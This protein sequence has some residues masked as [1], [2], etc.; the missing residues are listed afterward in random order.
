MAAANKRID[1]KWVVLLLVSVAYFLAQGTRHIYAAVLPQIKADLA[2]G[3]IDDTRLGLVSSV[4]NLVFGL[5]MPF[6]GLAADL[7]R[8]K[9]VLVTGSLLFAVGIFCSGFA[10]GL[11][12]LFI[13]YGILNAVGQSLM[14][15]CNTSFISQYHDRTRGTAFSLYQSAI[16]LGIIVCSIVSGYLAGMGE[17]GW[18]K[19]F[20]LFGAISFVWAVVM[21]LTLKDSQPG[22]S[23]DDKEG[24]GS[25]AEAFKAFARK[26]T[27]FVLMAALGFY[28]F[29]TYAFKT[30]SPMFMMRAFPEMEPARAIF[31]AVFWFYVGAL[32]GVTLGGRVSDRWRQL[33]RTARLDTELIGFALCVPFILVMASARSLPLMI[34]AIALFG[35]ATGIYDSNL[36][37]ALFEVIN[38]RY[39]A[40]AT[41][42]F[43]C[44]GCV[45]GALGPVVA[46]A[47]SDSFD[48]RIAF[49]SLALFALFGTASIVLARLVTFK[50]DILEQ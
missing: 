38:P 22:P 48:I 44:G 25:I 12:M 43:G 16:Y 35:F 31:H 17:G 15:P 7:L 3:G 24:L 23:A 46:G 5:M 30:W 33:S 34:V 10:T 41:G 19:A 18:R 27:S 49:A 40:V 8:R 26:P 2:S 29:T 28:F 42:L 4:F 1:Y 14:P 36:Y 47:L 21:L 11:G 50:K 37:A 39:R 32:G 45:V 6:A 20:W 9:W 13:S